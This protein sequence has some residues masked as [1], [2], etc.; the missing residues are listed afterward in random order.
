M[1]GLRDTFYGLAERHG[2]A[3]AQVRKLWEELEEAY[4]AAGRHYH[5]LEHLQNILARL[6]EVKDSLSD[7]DSILF[8]LFYHDIVYVIN[9]KENEEKSAELAVQR[10]KEVGISGEMQ[11]RIA[12]LIH[13]T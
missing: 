6:T 1:S 4:T 5:N 2:A 13:A 11:S 12:S 8:A 10:M 9:G 3:P 7:P